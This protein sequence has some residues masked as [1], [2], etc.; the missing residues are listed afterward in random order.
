M[1]ERNKNAL[2]ALKGD[3]LDGLLED[4]HGG[5]HLLLGD[6]E[7]GDESDDLSIA[8]VGQLERAKD[9]RRKWKVLTG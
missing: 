4:V 2:L 1:R 5:G 8:S 3:L 6:D 9:D 7:G